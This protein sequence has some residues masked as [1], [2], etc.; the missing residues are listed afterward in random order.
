MQDFEFGCVADFFGEFETVFEGGKEGVAVY[1]AF[2]EGE[3]EVG[4]ERECLRVDLRAAA[5]EHV[6]RFGGEID[7]AQIGNG[8]HAGIGKLR[9]AQDE[10]LAVRER[11]ADG[12]K[13][14][15]AH[16]DDIAGGKLFEPLEIVGQ[17]PGDFIFRA[18]HAIE[19]HGG[20]GLEVFHRIQ[21]KGCA[22][23]VNK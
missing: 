10:G 19:R 12:L 16:H 23:F 2:D 11:F 22:G 15:P 17:M 9:A 18:N 4:T 21:T 8:P 14:F 5:D 3:I 13:R 7:F 20:D 1:F 6:A